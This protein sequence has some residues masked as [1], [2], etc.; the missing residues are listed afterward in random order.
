MNKL[1]VSFLKYIFPSLLLL[2]LLGCETKVI[3]VNEV[4]FFIA[5]EWKIQSVIV[6]GE[7]VTDTDLSLYRLDLRDDF[8]FERIGIEGNAE[9]GNWKLTAG[10]SQVVLFV[11]DPREERYLLIDL[12]IRQMELKLLQE[13]FKDGELDIRYILT[14][15]KAQ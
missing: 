13:S 11:N 10:L 3:K 1:I 6:N 2:M 4:E 12:K 5:K 7:L 8:T 14:P 9:S 15:T